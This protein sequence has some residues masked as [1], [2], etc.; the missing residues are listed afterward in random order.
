M[1]ATK[2]KYEKN[3]EIITPERFKNLMKYHSTH[4]NSLCSRHMKMDQIMCMVL[5]QNG[6]GDGA[7]QIRGSMKW[8]HDSD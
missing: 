1:P 4:E 2:K 8:L 7:R 6:Y 3:Y 5:E